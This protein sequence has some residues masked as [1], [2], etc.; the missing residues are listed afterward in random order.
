MPALILSVDA[1]TQAPFVNLQRPLPWVAFR[2]VVPRVEHADD[3]LQ[4]SLDAI[5]AKQD[6]HREAVRLDRL[7]CYQCRVAIQFKA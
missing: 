5:G 4:V 2:P 1:E 7:P 6:L 3:V